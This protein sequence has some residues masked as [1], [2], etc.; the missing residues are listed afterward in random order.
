MT[1]F[2]CGSIQFLRAIFSIIIL[3][4]DFSALSK[5]LRKR[6]SNELEIWDWGSEQGVKK[7]YERA[8]D[9]YIS[10]EDRDN[11][12]AWKRVAARS[13]KACSIRVS[14]IAFYRR[15]VRW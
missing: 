2:V 6:K 8:W 5:I 7:R 4:R 13:E 12:E 3:L 10:R 15:V 1:K 9:A 11:D 14:F